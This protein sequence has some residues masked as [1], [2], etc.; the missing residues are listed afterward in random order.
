MAAAAR[1]AGFPAA[2][3]AA[4]AATAAAGPPTG[5][6]A[7]AVDVDDSAFADAL[8][9]QL[10]ARLHGASDQASRASEIEALL[11]V[12]RLCDAYPFP[13]IINAALLKVA[14]VFLAGYGR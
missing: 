10:L 1:A 13:T 9:L 8:L 12:P 4:A 11:L 5:T 2:W 14:D 7:A 6:A 3:V